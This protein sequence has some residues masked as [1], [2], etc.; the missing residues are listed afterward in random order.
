MGDKA[1]CILLD[2]LAVE[3]AYSLYRDLSATPYRLMTPPTG[4]EVVYVIAPWLV[5]NHFFSKKTA[6]IYRP[7]VANG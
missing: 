2:T 6:C 7:P 5:I 4:A 3:L 1:V